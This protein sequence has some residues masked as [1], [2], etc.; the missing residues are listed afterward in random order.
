MIDVRIKNIDESDAD[1]LLSDDMSFEGNIFLSRPLMIMGQVKGKIESDSNVFIEKDAEVR[2]DIIAKELS[3]KG[4]M[5]GSAQASI[6]ELGSSAVVSGEVKAQ[7]L[8]ME[9]GCSFDGISRVG[10]GYGSSMP[11]TY[12]EE[13]QTEESPAQD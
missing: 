6:I 7:S 4:T 10:L 8:A 11:K 3:V 2:A 13:N 1:T 9:S 12:A 5:D